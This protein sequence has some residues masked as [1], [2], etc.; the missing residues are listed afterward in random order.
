MTRDAVEARCEAL[1]LAQ[2]SPVADDLSRAPQRLRVEPS[3]AGWRAW[4]P[5]GCSGWGQTEE[6]ALA[7]LLRVAEAE[8]ER[9]AW[10][11]RQEARRAR[12][13]ARQAPVLDAQADAI[14]GLLRGR[15]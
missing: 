14:E 15:T 8:A 1:R 6:A 9:V 12:E 7:E 3:R 4:V 10:R 13:A 5:G 11:L 2:L